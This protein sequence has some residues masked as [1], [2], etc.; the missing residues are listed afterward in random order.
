MSGFLIFLED[1]RNYLNRTHM[2]WLAQ[3]GKLS[4]SGNMHITAFMPRQRNMFYYLS[5]VLSNN[6][7]ALPKFFIFALFMI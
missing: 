1:R 6:E 4:M 5:E 2:Q 7:M 3:T